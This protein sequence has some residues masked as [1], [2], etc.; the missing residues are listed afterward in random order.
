[1]RWEALFRDL[2]AQASAQEDEQW[3]QEVGERARGE[4]LSVSIAARIAA[5]R[6]CAIRVVLRDGS[7]AHGE[8]LDSGREWVLL[9]DGGRQ[10]LLALGAVSM[11]EALPRRADRLTAVESRLTIART[12]RAL[13]RER[14]RVTVRAGVELSG[15]IV[16]V[17][18]D[19]LDLVTDS[20]AA[21][22]VPLTAILEVVSGEASG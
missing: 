20:G 8:V 2:E 22:T 16:A 13:S 14:S 9:A 17:G 19:H 1:M 5:A 18:E 4:R 15:V 7:R 10:R 6:G 11:V 21:A 12:L 3:M